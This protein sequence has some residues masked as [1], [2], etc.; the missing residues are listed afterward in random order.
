LNPQ[1]YV[2]GGRSDVVELRPEGIVR[3][4][5]VRGFGAFAGIR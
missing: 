2:V 1:G 4:F 5:S 3:K